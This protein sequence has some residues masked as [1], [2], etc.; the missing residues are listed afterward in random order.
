MLAQAFTQQPRN[1]LRV[2]A[3]SL[4]YIQTIHPELGNHGGTGQLITGRLLATNVKDEPRLPLTGNLN[5]FSTLL[6]AQR[7]GPCNDDPSCFTMLVQALRLFCLLS[8]V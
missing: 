5:A 7:F 6:I 1:L 4:T 2:K 3:G 8:R